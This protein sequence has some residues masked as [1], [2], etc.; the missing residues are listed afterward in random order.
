MENLDLWNRYL[1]YYRVGWNI[2]IEHR[3]VMHS[4]TSENLLSHYERKCLSIFGASTHS[5]VTRQLHTNE[6]QYRYLVENSRLI[7]AICALDP[8]FNALKLLFL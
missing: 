3:G 4:H 1:E 5:D 8:D 6:P 7:D 2:L